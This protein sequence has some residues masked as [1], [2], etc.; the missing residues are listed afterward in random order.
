MQDKIKNKICFHCNQPLIQQNTNYIYLC[1]QDINHHLMIAYEEDKIRRIRYRFTESEKDFILIEDHKSNVSDI[2]RSNTN[3][4][5]EYVAGLEK[6]TRINK[7]MTSR[8]FGVE[9]LQVTI[10]NCIHFK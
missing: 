7:L 1:K 2:F 4:K 5:Y 3:T 10:K 9:S 8:V 6:A